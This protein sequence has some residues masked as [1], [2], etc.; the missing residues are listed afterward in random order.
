MHPIKSY[1]WR[2]VLSVLF[3]HFIYRSFTNTNNS[4]QAEQLKFWAAVEYSTPVCISAPKNTWVGAKV[5]SIEL[6]FEKEVAVTIDL[7]MQIEFM[8]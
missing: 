8:I 3:N 6:W 7:P 1:L 4:K 5:G 2:E